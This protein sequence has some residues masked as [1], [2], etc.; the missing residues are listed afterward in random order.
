MKLGKSLLE[1]AAAGQLSHHHQQTCSCQEMDE[2]TSDGC[3]ELVGTC[4]MQQVQADTS[5]P[6]PPRVPIKQ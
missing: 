2:C 1:A 6:P 3:L 5:L 4:P